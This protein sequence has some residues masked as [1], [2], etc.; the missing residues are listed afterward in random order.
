MRLKIRGI[1]GHRVAA[2]W[3][4]FALLAVLALS[5]TTGHARAAQARTAIIIVPTRLIP[6]PPASMPVLRLKTLP[7]PTS[8]VNSV[9]PN[10]GAKQTELVPL[11][12]LPFYHP[13]QF[14]PPPPSNLIGAFH[15]EDHLAAFEDTKTGQAAVYP[16]LGNQTLVD[17]EHVPAFLKRA[18][19]VAATTFAGKHLLPK[20]STH[21]VL[22]PALPL[23]GSMTTPAGGASPTM[24]YLASVPVKRMVGQ[25]LV[26]G[27]GSTSYMSFDTEM[28]VEG[29]TRNWKLANTFASVRETRSKTQIAKLIGSQ[30]AA[31]KPANA[32]VLTVSLAY[33][34]S[35]RGY[36]QP[37]YRF[38][39]KVDFGAA[40]GPLASDFEVGY[41]GIGKRYESIPVLGTSVGAS[42]TNDNPGGAPRSLPRRGAGPSDPCVG[43]YVVQNDSHSW[44]DSANGFYAGIS[45]YGGSGWFPNCQYYWAIQPQYNPAVP[46]VNSMNV[47]DSEGHGDWW[48]FSTVSNCCNPI[49]LNPAVSYSGDYKVP[50]PGYGAAAG[51]NTD[52]WII[53][54]C[55]VVP[56]PSDTA[57]WYGVWWNI[58]GGLHS[59]MGYR[60]IMY[61]A[62]GAMAPYGQ[63]L[64]LGA[65]AVAAWLGT[66][67]SLGAYSGG[68]TG[69]MHGVV[70]H[71]GR[72]STIS[73]SNQVNDSAYDT[74]AQPR[75]G[76]LT[77]FWYPG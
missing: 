69:T 17:A 13:P 60:T 31:L 76:G 57:N 20:D 58:F 39:A 71:L 7:P 12:Q 42:P 46:R 73:M 18:S 62:D 67:I 38:T 15:G 9:L 74:S 54:S 28:R 52:Y 50:F 10:V 27:P 41:V 6:T 40:A 24:A 53:H 11:S 77:T 2:L 26:D 64:R 25:Y 65:P 44:V 75:A 19:S 33:Y 35:N 49:N 21:Y 51:G 22:N 63:Q 4:A 37:V 1:G 30:L 56:S 23:D 48:V 43:R 5:Q 34:D 32:R 61:I 29:F 14:N 55:E 59:V 68:P 3:I 72:P 66:V 70:K 16:N 8:F 45:S 47:V 36:M